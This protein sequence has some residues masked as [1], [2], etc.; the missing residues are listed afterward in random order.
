MFGRRRGVLSVLLQI[1]ILWLLLSFTTNTVRQTKHSTNSNC[2]IK[3]GSLTPSNKKNNKQ[4]GLH[5][6]Q[7]L[8][9]YICNKLRTPVLKLERY[10]KY[11]V[12]GSLIKCCVITEM[13]FF[14]M[15]QKNMFIVCLRPTVPVILWPTV[16]T[17]LTCN[18]LFKLK[19]LTGIST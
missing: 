17:I 18:S 2:S 7:G 13:N 14:I 5:D 3:F 11:R 10:R 4:N 12:P 8:I 16:E 1:Y 15:V 6:L 19:K 9:L